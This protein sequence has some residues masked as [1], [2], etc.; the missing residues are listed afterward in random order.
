MQ[1][2]ARPGKRGRE[3][4]HP[5]GGE[6]LLRDARPR[7]AGREGARARAGVR[8]P[9]RRAGVAVAPR[10]GRRARA[11][12][13]RRPRRASWP[14]CSSCSARPRLGAARSSTWSARPGSA[15][16]ASS[17][18]FVARW[19]RPAKPVT[20]LEGQ[21]VSFGQTIPFLPIVD[22]LRRELR[23]RGVRRRARDH[24][25]G[26]AWHAAD[27]ASSRPHIPFIRS[28][29]A[30]DPGDPSV[31]AM[32]AQAPPAK[33]VRGGPGA[34]AAGGTS[35]VRSCSWSRTCTGSTR[36]SEE[37]LGSAHRLGGRA[38]LSCSSSRIGSGTRR[39]SVPAASRPRSPFARLSEAGDA[40]HGR[41][42]ARHARS[43]RAS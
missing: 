6:R 41:S 42:G 37:Y 28:L 30:V 18:S 35:C 23:D 36:T 22:Q 17:S 3:R 20:W 24:R 19:R 43:S 38:C 32:D 27:G 25:Q 21:C 2:A 34:D 33:S 5:Q 12:A 13:A 16:H 40:E 11:H 39:R 7:G 4:G 10:R 8:G 29:L 14:R 26:R 15:S 9:A 1:Q 31:A